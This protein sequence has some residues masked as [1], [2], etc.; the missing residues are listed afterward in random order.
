MVRLGNIA[1]ID[2][3]FTDRRPPTGLAEI[4]AAS[5]VDLHVT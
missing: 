5:D 2:C 4:I 3:L 1:E